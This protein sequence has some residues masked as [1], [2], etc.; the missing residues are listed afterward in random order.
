L[1]WS[2]SNSEALGG[3]QVNLL[4][5]WEPRERIDT[6]SL[7]PFFRVI[8]TKVHWE[9]NHEEGDSRQEPGHEGLG[10]IRLRDQETP[11]P[12]GND[13]PV[14][15][16]LQCCGGFLWKAPQLC[17]RP[18]TNH[19]GTASWPL[20]QYLLS[21]QQ[22]GQRKII[23]PPPHCSQQGQRT[24]V[25]ATLPGLLED[26]GD[27]MGAGRLGHWSSCQSGQKS[28]LEGTLNIE[29]HTGAAVNVYPPAVQK[30]WEPQHLP[31]PVV[32]ATCHSTLMTSLRQDRAGYSAGIWHQIPGCKIRAWGL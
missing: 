20:P 24:G 2:L 31:V 12:S 32:H 21:S 25:T 30:S 18:Y 7:G 11:N 28:H 1:T 5:S 29:R 10:G 16:P 4:Q 3:R 27:Q 23:P 6:F 14:S 15:R 26:V 13:T 19:K 8:S 9:L 17:T 22:Q